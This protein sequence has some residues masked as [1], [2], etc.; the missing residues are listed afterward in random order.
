MILAGIDEAGYGPMLGP[1]V[2]SA[3]VFRAPAPTTA[4]AGRSQDSA[5]DLWQRL[6]PLVTRR[7]EA[8]R[9]AVN[10]S[11]KLFSQQKGV[12]A[13][14][15]GLLPFLY[16]R[17]GRVPRGLR[18][19]LQQISRRGRGAADAYLDEYPWYRGRD[20]TIPND[21]W[22][23][24][25]ERQAAKL[26]EVSA[27]AGV[28]FLGVASTPIEVIE[29]NRGIERED[30]KSQVSFL[31]IGRFLRRLWRQY[32]DED[33]DVVVDRQGG[34]TQYAR[35]LFA[36]VKPQGLAIDVESDETSSYRLL[37]RRRPGDASLPTFRVTFTKESEDH[38]L[39]VALASMSAKYVRELHMAIFNR[40][41]VEQQSD[42]RPTAGYVVDARRF[43]VDTS[44][45]R[46]RLGID[47][48]LLIRRK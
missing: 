38:S 10:D 9:I 8:G 42:L 17:H 23:A 35:H 41:F 45:L 6:A 11:K 15:E 20:V 28:E 7:P 46:A 34:R 43:L 37:R 2:V 33:V 36:A 29:L 40:Y 31:A 14:E 12:G 24:V 18:E 5:S 32:G 13:L 3:A 39:P 1:L 22:N 30:K 25:I 48:A 44:E 4:T 26:A 47:P 16:L 27:A 21:T 19:L